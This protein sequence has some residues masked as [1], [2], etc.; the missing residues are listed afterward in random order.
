M[1]IQQQSTSKHEF[2]LDAPDEFPEVTG[3]EDNLD[4]I[5]TNLI[6]NAIKYSPAGGEVTIHLKVDDGNAVVGVQDRGIGIPKEHMPKVFDRFHRVH[7]QD[8]RKIYGTGLG[9]FLV[10]HLVEMVHL[11]KVWAESELGVGSTFW[12]SIPLELDVEKAEELNK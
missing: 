2:V 10:Q 3:D 12:F 11:G 5:L 6:S 1:M 7:T 8:N 9:L 4:Q